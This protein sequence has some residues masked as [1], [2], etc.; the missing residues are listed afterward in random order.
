MNREVA[1]KEDITGAYP[2][3]QYPPQRSLQTPG[4]PWP[5]Y[6]YIC[7]R[8]IILIFEQTSSVLSWPH[9]QTNLEAAK[10]G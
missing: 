1:R 7:T 10:Q 6:M 2:H 4:Q 8:H 5:S 3:P 9:S